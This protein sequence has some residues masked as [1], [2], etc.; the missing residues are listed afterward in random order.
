MKVNFNELK[1]PVRV[2]IISNCSYILKNLDKKSN[3]NRANRLLNYLINNGHTICA[4]LERIDNNDKVIF[5]CEKEDKKEISSDIREW[6][7]D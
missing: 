4:K 2:K 3:Y 7:K 6:F 1:N 5:Y